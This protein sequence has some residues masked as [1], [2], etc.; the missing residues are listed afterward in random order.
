MSP[1]RYRGRYL[2]S[3]AC[4]SRSK[5][6]SRIPAGS[7]PSA[8]FGVRRRDR[9]E[10]GDEWG[11]PRITILGPLGEHPQD[12]RLERVGHRLLEFL[13]PRRQGGADLF[14][15]LLRRRAFAWR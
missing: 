3:F 7:P 13:R 11:W 14:D 4:A 8:L 2:S 5:A 15:R 1:N 9:F 12:D 6:D 10:I